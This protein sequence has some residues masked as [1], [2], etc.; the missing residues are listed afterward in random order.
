MRREPC[1]VGVG[2]V[3][4]QRVDVEILDDV[5]V[6]VV[7]GAD[8][9]GRGKGAHRGAALTGERCR[10][11][12]GRRAGE[13]SAVADPGCQIVGRDMER[14]TRGRKVIGGR[15]PYLPKI[16]EYLLVLR[17]GIKVE[18]VAVADVGQAAARLEEREYG[19]TGNGGCR[20]TRRD[21]GAG[22][23]NRL[24]CLGQGGGCEGQ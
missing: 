24:L 17:D 22:E 21:P 2:I 23:C 7:S 11:A 12:S 10:K 16:S 13:R 14:C 6:L 1:V 18:R 3:G 4:R 5:G 9:L 19:F 8:N 15:L 20:W